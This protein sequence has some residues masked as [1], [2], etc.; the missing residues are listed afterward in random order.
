MCA[1]RSV[2]KRS[3]GKGTVYSLGVV[4]LGCSKNRVDTQLMLGI[5]RKAG[6]RIT[7]DEREADLLIVHPCRF[8]QPAKPDVILTPLPLAS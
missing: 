2:K 8:I 3:A 6:S 4:S 1:R 5:L 7:A